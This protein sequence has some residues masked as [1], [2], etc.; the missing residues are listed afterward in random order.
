[1]G[2]GLDSRS[3][4]EIARAQFGLFHDLSDRISLSPDDRRRALD[5]TDGDWRAWHD[6]LADGPMPARPPLP[7]MLW[8]L[9]HV[10]FN[11]TLIAEP[12]AEPRDRT[13][14]LQLLPAGPVRRY[15]VVQ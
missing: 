13:S 15:K 14:G 3:G 8:R 10:A 11:L 2:Q 9:G 1:M 5:L 6:F 12:D 4:G 7:E